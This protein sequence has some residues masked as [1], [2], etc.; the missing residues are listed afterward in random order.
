VT[1]RLEDELVDL[2]AHLDVPDDDVAARRTAN[3]VS[4]RVRSGDGSTSPPPRWRRRRT[5]IPVGVV[6]AATA[7]VASPAMGDWFGIRGVEVVPRPPTATTTT[8]VATAGAS[9][10]LGRPSTTADATKVLGTPPVL[11]AA[12]GTPDEV[13]LD[14]RTA[15][16]YVS[17]V[18]EG[19]PL[20]SEF[21]ATMADTNIIT[22]FT[23]GTGQVE[24]MRI[25][26]RRAMWI[27]GVHQVVLRARNGDFVPDRLRQS[28]S[29]LLVQVGDLTVRIETSAGRDEAIRIARSLG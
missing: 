3:V 7:L 5:W 23:Q 17:F 15:A 21:D 2:A 12:L 16:P 29:V 19:G 13:W 27:E 25:D 20:V 9:L 10:D 6:V 4:A 11:P 14:S 22:K 28:D 24:E 1:P 8:T 26:G 18:Y